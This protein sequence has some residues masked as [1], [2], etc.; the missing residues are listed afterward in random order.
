MPSVRKK[1]LVRQIPTTLPRRFQA[2]AGCPLSCPP[3]SPSIATRRLLLIATR[4]AERL[5]L[6][7]LRRPHAG[8]AAEGREQ[9]VAWLPASLPV[10]IDQADTAVV[11]CSGPHCLQL[12]SGGSAT[13]INQRRVSRRLG[14]S[15]Y[16]TLAAPT[17]RWLTSAAIGDRIRRTNQSR[18]RKCRSP[19]GCR[20]LDCR[21]PREP[22]KWD[23]TDGRV[24]NASSGDADLHGTGHTRCGPAREPAPSCFGAIGL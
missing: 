19:A 11:S 13:E 20:P 24:E 16:P 18:T 15:A 12:I 10:Q 9:N 1:P 21:A 6:C 14:A 5:A 4:L 8:V 3:S 17:S 2:T 22:K 7:A 23:V